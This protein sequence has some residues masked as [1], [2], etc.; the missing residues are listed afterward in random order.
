MFFCTFPKTFFPMYSVR[1]SVGAL[2]RQISALLRLRSYVGALMSALLCRRSIVV[3]SFDGVPHLSLKR[4]VNSYAKAKKKMKFQLPY[5][6]ICLSGPWAS[7]K[8]CSSLL[9]YSHSIYFCPCLVL[10][11]HFI[12][13]EA[14]IPWGNKAEV[15]IIVISG[16]N[17]HFRGKRHFLKNIHRHSFL[18]KIG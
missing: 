16:W 3:R 5:T 15:F 1:S 9:T 14:S 4:A 18:A 2:C 11:Q 10:M 13:A 7:Q 6:H 8:H 12:Q 17:Y